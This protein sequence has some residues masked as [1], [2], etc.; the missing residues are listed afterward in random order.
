MIYV[1][2]YLFAI[3]AANL[4]ITAFGPSVSIVTA[5][6]FIGLDLTA[7]D[8]LHHQW[9]HDRL[10]LKMTGLIAA[11]SVLSFA[12]NR[13]SAQIA[14]ASLVAF[15]AAA[16]VDT[17]LFHVLIDRPYMQRVNGSNVPAAI[18]DSFLFPTLAFGAFLPVIVAGQIV[19]KVGGG[20]FWSVVFQ[21]W[22]KRKERVTA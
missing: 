8:N 3:V 14:I 15:S 2:L 6:L 18:V 9:R 17:V 21:A 19:A 11:G 13:D 16:V 1:F 4:I 5:F 10:V 7:R 12:I 20:F 22:Q